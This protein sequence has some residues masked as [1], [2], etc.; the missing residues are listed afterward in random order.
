M[1][2]SIINHFLSAHVILLAK[3]WLVGIMCLL[4]AA[5]V[6]EI[7]VPS[8][9]YFHN[10]ADLSYTEGKI[11]LIECYVLMTL[12]WNL[13]HPNA[14]HYLRHISKVEDYDL[15]AQT[16]R[17]YLLEVAVLRWRLLA[18][19]PSLI[20]I[21]SIWLTGLILS[22]DRWTPNLAHYSIYAESSLMPTV[23]LMLR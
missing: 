15:K 7:V 16:I 8:I 1:H 17:K 19:P 5:K 3:L 6:E 9:L 10:C 22:H 21:A 23:N 20:T 4:L 11:L 12:D 2:A 14:M 13:S 18:M